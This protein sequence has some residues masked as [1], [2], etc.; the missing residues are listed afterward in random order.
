MS[1]V[2]ILDDETED[3][4]GGGRDVRPWR[5]AAIRCGPGVA[6]DALLEHVVGELRGSGLR[7]AGFVQQTAPADDDCCGVTRLRNLRD[8][9]LVAISQDL[10]AGARGCRLDPGALARAAADLESSLGV[11]IDLVVLNRF[12]RAEAEGRGMRDVIEFALTAGFPVL[13]PVRDEH[14]DAWSRFHGGLGAVLSSDTDAI[15]A[16]CRDAVRANATRTAAAH[17]SR[18]SHPA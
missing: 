12:G 2:A 11:D 6:V 1:D 7:L 17:R 15:V 16:W 5:I 10:G 8:D 18:R 4:A 14:H 3:G 13:L 9:S